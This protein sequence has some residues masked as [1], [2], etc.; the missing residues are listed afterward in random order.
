MTGTQRLRHYRH[1]A[2]RVGILYRVE[3]TKIIRLRQSYIG[4]LILVAIVLLSPLAHPLVKDDMGDYGFIAYVT[5]LTLGFLGYV[6]L[7]SF[8]SGLFATELGRGTLRAVLLRPVKREEIYLA[9]F[10]MGC[11][12]STLLTVVVGIASWCVT[13]ALGDLY[14]IQV[15]GELLYTGDDMAW[16]YIFG[17]ILALAPQ[18]A[19][20]SLGLLFSSITRSTGTAVSLSIGT[21]VALDLIKYPLGIDRLVFTSYL[22]APWSVFANHCDGLDASWF[23]MLYYCLLSS[24]LVGAISLVIGIA[25]FKRR[26]LSAC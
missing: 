24:A 19:G 25:L 9:K 20:V 21:W 23:P 10:L 17:S 4:P 5:P 13:I 1:S 7:L 16:A 12:Y 11:T 2:K 3:L 15:G 6:L 8:V 22:E 14:G 18:W 26:N